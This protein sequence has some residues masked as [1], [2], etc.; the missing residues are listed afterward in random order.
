M[1]EGRQLWFVVTFTTVHA[2]V[3]AVLFTLGTTTGT[4]LLA[5]ASLITYL[6][7]ALVTELFPS[8][9]AALPVIILNSALWA[10]VAGR[11]YTLVL[12]EIATNGEQPIP[13]HLRQI[14]IHPHSPRQVTIGI[15]AL[16]LATSL[17]LYGIDRLDF[18]FARVTPGAWTPYN[19]GV[20]M[21]WLVAAGTVLAQLTLGTVLVLLARLYSR[22]PRTIFCLYLGSWTLTIGWLAILVRE[23]I[24]SHVWP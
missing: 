12:Q 1:T 3:T 4:I 21:W 24:V 7:G 23:V 22:F 18:F 15:I 2:A 10:F 20:F 14:V 19:E 16:W 9:W 5:P 6:Q 17:G 8:L 11:I 13:R